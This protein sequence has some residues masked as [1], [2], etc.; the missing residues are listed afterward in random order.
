[1]QLLATDFTANLQESID[2]YLSKH[3]SI[4]AFLSSVTLDLFKGLTM[5]V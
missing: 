1:M 5:Q 4:P 3:N 2:L